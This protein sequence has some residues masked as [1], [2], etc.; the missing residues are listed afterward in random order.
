VDLDRLAAAIELARET[1]S[2]RA[3]VEAIR[4]EGWRMMTGRLT[5]DEIMG[6][7]SVTPEGHWI[8]N[9]RLDGDGYGVYSG[10]RAHRVVWMAFRGELPPTLHLDH[11]CR[12]R[13][14]V[15]PDGVFH[16]QPVTPLE[17]TRRAMAVK[18]LNADEVVH[19][20]AKRWC[21]RGHEFDEKNTG[22]D[23]R[24]NRYC[25]KCRHDH[26]TH[27][28]KNVLGKADAT[29]WHVDADAWLAHRARME[30]DP[31]DERLSSAEVSKLWE[32]TI[33]VLGHW[34]ARNPH[35]IDRRKDGRFRS[36]SARE[37]RAI[38]AFQAP[39]TWDRTKKTTK[40]TS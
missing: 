17:N 15:N 14:C 37:A 18:Q 35:L 26:L 6:M 25:K 20:G 24:G 30:P 39:H 12:V 36:Y 13:Q 16:L 38:I 21:V 4:A 23:R 7:V 29:G 34:F 40:E 3:L 22:R 9:G 28:Y 2:E 31:D 33:D 5:Q 27:Y 19:H 32:V 10:R 8:W 11:V 1:G